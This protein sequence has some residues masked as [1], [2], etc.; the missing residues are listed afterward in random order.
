MDS[1]VY[2]ASEVTFRGIGDHKIRVDFMKFVPDDIS[3]G[4]IEQGKF[5]CYEIKSCKED[6]N[7]G[8]GLNC[9]GDMNYLVTTLEF[10]QELV[11]LTKWTKWGVYVCHSNG[12]LEC[13][14]KAKKTIRKCPA[15]EMLLAMF[16][17]S[18]RELLKYRESY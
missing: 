12:T 7:S 4:G 3:A 16:R 18:N 10:A 6:Y 8:H 14:K 1:R 17:S 13:I 11:E 15:A 2:T 5:Y 9:I